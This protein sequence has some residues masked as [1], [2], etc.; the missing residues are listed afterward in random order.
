VENK[1]NAVGTVT[2][3]RFCVCCRDFGAGAGVGVF[4]S[5]LP[6]PPGGNDKKGHRFLSSVGAKFW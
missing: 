1:R 3:L 2:A 4:V 6:V 5:P